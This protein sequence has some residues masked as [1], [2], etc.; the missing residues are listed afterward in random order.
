MNTAKPKM[1]MKAR[2]EVPEFLTREQAAMIMHEVDVCWQAQRDERRYC[3]ETI[4]AAR[5]AIVILQRWAKAEPL[6]DVTTLAA[7]AQLFADLE[8]AARDAVNMGD[9]TPLMPA[10]AAISAARPNQ[11]THRPASRALLEERDALAAIGEKM[12]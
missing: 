4:N 9:L 3:A 10:L 2:P 12:P 11:A 5:E 8:S 7:R 1:P 6:W